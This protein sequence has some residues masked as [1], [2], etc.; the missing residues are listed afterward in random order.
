MPLS[1]GM[2][3]VLESSAFLNAKPA[4]QICIHC[5]VAR[6]N[7]LHTLWGVLQ[8]R[9]ADCTLSATDLDVCRYL[10]TSEYN[11]SGRLTPALTAAA[12][13]AGTRFVASSVRMLSSYMDRI[14]M[15]TAV[16]RVDGLPGL[17][18]QIEVSFPK[19]K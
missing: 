1:F 5:L 9:A 12:A 18:L 3:V 14:I 11:T 8:G 15:A 4:M 2:E 16:P 7:L 10:P 19:H 17:D 13:L 6:P